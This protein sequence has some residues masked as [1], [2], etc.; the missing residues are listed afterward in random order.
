LLGDDRSVTPALAVRLATLAEREDNPH[1]RG[2]LASSAKRLPSS[3]SLPVLRNL[4]K[5]RE[6]VND[7]HIPL[8]IWWAL[9]AK[10]E[11]DR[12]SVVRLFRDPALWKE[13]LAA[14]HLLERIVQRY[15][16]AGGPEN[17]AACATLLRLP[18]GPLEAERIVSGLEKAFAGRGI[19]NVP[20]DF[21]V[22][23]QHA[24]SVAGKSSS[25]LTLGVRLGLAEAIDEAIHLAGDPKARTEDRLRAVR[26]LA[27]APQ[28]RCVPVLLG[29]VRTAPDALRVEILATLQRYDDP[30]IG[31]AVLGLNPARLPDTNGLRGAAFNLLASRPGW[32]LQLVQAVDIGRIPPSGIPSEVVRKSSLHKNEQLAKL[33]RKHWGRLGPATSQEKQKEMVRLLNLARGGKGDAKQGKAVYANTCAKCHKLF[34]EG[35]VVGPDLTGYERDNL[36]F[37]VENIVDPSA[38]I[39]EEYTTTVVETKDGRVLTGILA[40]QDKQSILLRDPEGKEVRLA[41]QDLAEMRASSVSIMPEGQLGTLNEQQIRDLFAYLTRQGP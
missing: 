19:S 22:A 4:I 40:S 11:S 27:E 3:A 2:Q 20:A 33:V 41:R 35:G 14:R 26:V 9:E 7:P 34:G 6:D 32:A 16:M 18:P 36:L 29:L 31:Q 12:D 17:L 13:P 10:A 38:A 15:A 25:T 8:L 23:I 39:R 37:W 24:L 5:H 1:V 21:K 30:S 28:P